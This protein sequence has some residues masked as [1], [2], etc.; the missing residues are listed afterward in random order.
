M[1]CG[2]LSSFSPPLPYI[3]LHRPTC[4]LLRDVSLG[5]LW[6]INVLSISWH[7]VFLPS[8]IYHSC[9]NVLM[10]LDSQ[11]PKHFVCKL[12]EGNFVDQNRHEMK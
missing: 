8:S 9:N 1:E 11:R 5:R 6:V 2:S 10:W 3:T 12:E 7:I 4:H